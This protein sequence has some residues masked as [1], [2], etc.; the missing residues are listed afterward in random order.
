MKGGLDRQDCSIFGQYRIVSTHI[1]PLISQ[2]FTAS[3]LTTIWS[4][5]MSNTSHNEASPS[6]SPNIPTGEVV[7]YGIVLTILAV[8]TLLGNSLVCLAIWRFRNLR[9]LTN[10]FVCSLAVADLLV[11]LLR[12]IY[13]AVS[14]FAGK[15]LFGRTWCKISSMCGILLCGASIMHLCAISIERLI[16][17]K[18]PLSYGVRVTHRRVVLALVYIWIQ[19]AI[20]S[21]LP[22][23]GIA[24]HR[25]NPTLME[26]EIAWLKKPTLTVLL[27]V[28]YFFV[29]TSIM[30]FAYML[31][32]KEVRRST[33]RISGIAAERTGR[34]SKIASIFMLREIKAVK[35]LAVVIGVFF[36]M[37]MPYFVA[38]TIRAFR[39][40]AFVPAMLQR[41]VITLAYG[42]SCCNFVIYALM[43]QQLRK[44]FMQVLKSC[45]GRRENLPRDLR[46]T[47]I[48]PTSERA[49]RYA[50]ETKAVR[51]DGNT[52]S[53]LQT[54]TF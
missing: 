5:E 16:A 39:G 46:M 44:A 32:F 38:T 4:S 19:S 15:W 11:P 8:F 33:R 17:I 6:F 22:V 54:L 27:V 52:K 23:F 51:A 50:A 43:N 36:V 47:T 30:M 7:G 37:W 49:S 29:P 53:G 28:F 10:Y 34:A 13:I 18:W 21:V 42:N 9:N 14:L 25:F 45:N 20:L 40:E 35:V 1:W 3:C 48:S 31:I 24:E 41:T 2:H 12:V 26:C